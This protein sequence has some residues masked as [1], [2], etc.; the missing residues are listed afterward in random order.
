MAVTPA[1]PD[2]YD[3]TWRGK[4]RVWESPVI[5][6]SDTLTIP[7][8]KRVFSITSAKTGVVIFTSSAASGGN[9]VVVTMTVTASS[10]GDRQPL[11]VYGQ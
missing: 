10:T 4:I 8:V 1:K 7:G 6:T 9:G 11:V 3:G 2:F 5:A